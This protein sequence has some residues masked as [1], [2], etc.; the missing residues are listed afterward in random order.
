[1]KIEILK[2]GISDIQL[3]EELAH[4]TWN[5]HYRSIISQEQIDFMLEKMYSPA[6]LTEQMTELKHNFYLI[7]SD[8]IPV[9]FVSVSSPDKK[10]W[11]LHKFYILSEGQKKGTGSIV[12]S[13]L[14]KLLGNPQS[15]RLTVNRANYKSINFYFKNGFIIEK[16]ADFDIG[17]GYFMNDFVMLWQVKDK[18]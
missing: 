3:L 13:Q 11:M 18:G 14:L 1:M 15:I 6:S 10:N 7:H 8:N 9:G 16:V 5:S 2:A 12:Y 4:K 17:N